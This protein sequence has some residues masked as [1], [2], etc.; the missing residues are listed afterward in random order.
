MAKAAKATGE[1]QVKMIVDEEGKVIWA[2]AISGQPLLQ[3]T[4]VRAACRERFSPSHVVGRNIKVKGAG[5]I[6]YNFKL[7]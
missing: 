5:L 4:A 2:R 3:P 6:T 7:P 1:V